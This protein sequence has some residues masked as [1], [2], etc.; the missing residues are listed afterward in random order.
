M[1]ADSAFGKNKP[2]RHLFLRLSRI[3]LD[4]V[5]DADLMHGQPEAGCTLM[6]KPLELA[7]HFEIR[8][9]DF[10]RVF[11]INHSEPCPSKYSYACKPLT[12]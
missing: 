5:Q 2:F 6:G 10:D 7:G 3:L 1:E 9:I 12:M 8:M 11:R 4:G